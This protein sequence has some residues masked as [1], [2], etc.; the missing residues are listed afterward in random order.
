MKTTIYAI[1]TVVIFE[2]FFSGCESVQ[3]VLNVKRPKANLTGLRFENASLDS[4]TLLFNIEIENPYPVS[5]PLTNV[6]YGL[7]S[8]DNPFLS[9][10][11]QIAGT[12]PANS[13]KT[14]S[15]PAKVN[16]LDM[17]KTL[18]DVRLGTSIPY[19]ADV[20]LSMDTPALGVLRLPLKKEGQVMLPAPSDIDA[21]DIWN[22]I[23]GQ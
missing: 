15:L 23:R 8:G 6:D 14:V 3:G 11:T 18:K 7:S 16:Y 17:L 12:V 10:A 19:R 1:L 22:I 21:R 5:L 4:A 13:N 2:P 20:G 9:G